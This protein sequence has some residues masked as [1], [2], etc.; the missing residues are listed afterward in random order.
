[1]ALLYR[2]STGILGEKAELAVYRD[3]EE[4]LLLVPLMAAPEEPKRDLIELTGKQPMAGAVVGNLSPAYALE[5]G[6]PASLTGVIVASVKNQSV[7]ARYSIK[8]GDVIKSVNNKAV[9]SSRQLEQLLTKADGRWVI[10]LIRKGRTLTFQV[11]R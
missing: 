8:P 10:T 5:I 7:A 1:Q 11:S 9:S 3:G 6:A 2:I 4:A